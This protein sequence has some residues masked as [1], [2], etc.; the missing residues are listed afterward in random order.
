MTDKEIVEL[1]VIFDGVREYSSNEILNDK[2]LYNFV[3]RNI[4]LSP[5][6]LLKQIKK[7]N[8]NLVMLT[9]QNFTT[10]SYDL[11]NVS[12]ELYNLFLER[13]RKDSL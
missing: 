11:K 5:A 9:N 1:T 10:L 2:I 6:S 7:E 8:G 3:T 4:M 13:Y 12:Q